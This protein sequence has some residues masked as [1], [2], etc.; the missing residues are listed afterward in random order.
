MSTLCLSQLLSIVIGDGPIAWSSSRTIEP[1]GV[2]ATVNRHGPLP[3]TGVP[4]AAASPSS[5]GTGSAAPDS[6]SA[7]SSLP[8]AAA[9]VGGVVGAAAGAGVAPGA[10]GVGAATGCGAARV[11]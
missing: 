2:V 6:V 7:G 5:S 10:G 9:A 4:P 8:A 1:A 3:T 11:D